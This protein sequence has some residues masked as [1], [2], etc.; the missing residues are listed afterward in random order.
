MKEDQQLVYQRSKIEIKEKFPFSL[1]IDEIVYTIR[2]NLQLSD[3]EKKEIDLLDFDLTQEEI[4][5]CG[6]EK[7]KSLCQYHYD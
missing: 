6:F 5:F 3:P 7:V 1:S 4:K 2:E